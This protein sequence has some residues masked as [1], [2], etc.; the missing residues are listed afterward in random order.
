MKK[1]N[2][3]FIAI[4]I[5]SCNYGFNDGSDLVSG[6]STTLNNTLINSETSTITYEFFDDNTGLKIYCTDQTDSYDNKDYTY[7]GIYTFEYK[8]NI[9]ENSLYNQLIIYNL[10]KQGSTKT[11]N[12]ENEKFNYYFN[13]TK[14]ILYLNEFTNS[15]KIYWEDFKKVKYKY[16]K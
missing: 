3:L 13:A 10:K 9:P 15:K 2:I 16:S 7:H 8:I 14:D 1:I 4:A 6:W 12:L 5:L 11:S